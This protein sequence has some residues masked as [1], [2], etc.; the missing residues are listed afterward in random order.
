MGCK[1]MVEYYKVHKIL[2]VEEQLAG[3]EREMWI[4]E[5]VVGAHYYVHGQTTFDQ[6][7]L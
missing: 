5:H 1:R 3:Y 6:G 4:D 7:N 2:E